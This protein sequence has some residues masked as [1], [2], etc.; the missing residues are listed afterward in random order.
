MKLDLLVN[1]ICFSIFISCENAFEEKW[2][3]I[4]IVNFVA[5]EGRCWKIT[6]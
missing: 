4:G 3:E 6:Y 1:F 2:D 5:V